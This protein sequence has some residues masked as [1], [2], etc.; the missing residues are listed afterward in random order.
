LPVSLEEKKKQYPQ[1]K[2]NSTAK[3]KKQKI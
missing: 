3:D 1:L 2:E